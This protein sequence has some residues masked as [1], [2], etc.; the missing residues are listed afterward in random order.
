MNQRVIRPAEL[1]D[2]ESVFSMLGRFATSYKPDRPRFGDNYP[3]ALED[4]NT[5]VLVAE[6][7]GQVV[8]YILASDSLTLFANGV[9]AELLELY[10]GEKDRRKG[11]GRALVQT[12]ITRAKKRG[13]IEVTVPTRRAR[14][15]Y[16]ALNFEHTA[17]FFKLKL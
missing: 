1:R 2:A 12:A 9:V 5:D 4:A 16:L 15:F 17:E 3:R 7:V 13:V 8:G 11:I 6:N 10:V 14:P